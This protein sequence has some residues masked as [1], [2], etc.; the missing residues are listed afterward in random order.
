LSTRDR[1]AAGEGLAAPDWG[2]RHSL[3]LLVAIA[4][5]IGYADRVNLSVAAIPMQ[6]HLGWSQTV[7]GTVL[8]AFFAGYLAFMIVGGWLA[9]R[10]GGRRVVGYAVLWWSAWT[11]LTPLAAQISLPALLAAR[12]AI[13]AGEALLWPGNFD[14]MSRW[15][16]RAEYTGLTA[17]TGSGI[18]VGA[19]LGLLG[20]GWLLTRFDWPIAFYACGVVG[21]A[22][23][24][25]WFRVV[26]D[27]PEDD[28]GVSPAERALLAREAER[29][30]TTPIGAFR[31]VLRHP[32]AW[33]LFGAH[34]ANTWTLYVL[35]SWLPSYLR[36]VQHVAVGT[37]GIWSAGPWLTM[38]LS[39][40]VGTACADR[41][42]A[43]TGNVALARKAMQA[44]GL[45][46]SA[47]LL[48]GV[49]A[50]PNSPVLVLLLLCAATG[51]L[52][53]GWSAGFS[54]NYLDIAPTHGAL[55]FGIGSTIATIPGVVGVTVTGWL[56][57]VSGTYTAAFV[58]AAAV[59]LAGTL[60]FTV[61]GRGQPITC[62]DASRGG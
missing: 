1:R 16:P 5:A 55:L 9:G 60:A 21:I 27:R 46:G 53:L 54:A 4:S 31:S 34:F 19:V 24:A 25:G 20:T 52:G 18:P 23:C 33:A 30:R 28:P 36:D 48:L 12:V 11:L 2:R 47:A 58:L 42:I 49:Q 41:I 44:L 43:R 50:V 57:D 7:K 35:L 62:A 39:I 38:F 32:A 26:R 37:A 40:H 6:Q 51:L 15:A 3:A 13:G 10:F 45:L 22:W 17:I 8:A 61:F 29:V 14:L 59:S 56:V